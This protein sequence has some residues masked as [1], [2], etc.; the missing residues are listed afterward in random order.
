MEGLPEVLVER[1]LQLELA[2]GLGHALLGQVQRVQ[3][4]RLPQLRVLKTQVTFAFSFYI[5]LT[6][7]NVPSVAPGA[8]P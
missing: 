1:H 4:D 2:G 3:P 7:C 6:H 8:A 5:F